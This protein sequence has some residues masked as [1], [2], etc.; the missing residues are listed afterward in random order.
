MLQLRYLLT[1]TKKP[2]AVPVELEIIVRTIYDHP[3]RLVILSQG[4]HRSDIY[5]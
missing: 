5:R 3:I 4:S 2:V 1:V